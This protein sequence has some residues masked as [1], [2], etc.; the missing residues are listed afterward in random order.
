MKLKLGTRTSQLAMAQSKLVRDALLKVHPDI[1]IEFV[2]VK[3]HGD[4]N[5]KVP[6]WQLDVVGA[7]SKEI[8]EQVLNG[9]VDF[10]VHS[11]KDLGTERPKGLTTAAIPMRENSRDAILFAPHIL[12]KLANDEEI[13]IGTSAPRRMEL[14]PAFLKEA[15]PQLGS[16]PP[17]IKTIPT[18]GTVNTRLSRV[19]Q[20][21]GTDKAVDG[22]ALAFA[23]L[24]RLLAD[25]ESRNEATD[26]LSGLRWMVM[27]VTVCPGAP[28]QGAMCVEAHEDNTAVLEILKAIHD[29]VTAQQIDIERAV[30]LEHGGGCHQKFGVLTLALPTLNNPI[31]IIQGKTEDGKDVS[32]LRWEASD[33]PQPM[34]DGRQWNDKIF[35]FNTLPAALP[36]TSAVF[37][38]SARAVPDNLSK[39]TRLWVSGTSSWKKLAAKGYWVE[40]CADG[41]GFEF[42]KPTL[43]DPVLDLPNLSDWAILTHEAALSTWNVGQPVA[44]YRLIENMQDDALQ[45]L[46]N[47]K[48]IY[49][50][51]FSQFQ[52]LHQ[53]APPDAIHTCGPGKTA[54]LIGKAQ[55]GQLRVLLF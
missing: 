23:G 11:L 10:A 32:D 50:S 38:A 36:E 13:I 4:K 40:G 39:D 22:A 3:T 17:Q 54:E 52:S 35:E 43:Q 29:P 42:I 16:K 2:G 1:E 48:T 31:T 53:H 44:T 34:W 5:Q 8:D 33:L 45:N 12:D 25:D 41:F 30:L 51:S 18:R 47:A 19:R 24:S 7:F 28:G 15:L 37:A 9:T 49:W 6:L 20:S 27:P 26:L 14:I 21:P 55:P 46:K